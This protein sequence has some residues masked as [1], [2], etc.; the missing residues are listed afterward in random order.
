MTKLVYGDL[1]DDANW[2]K[3]VKRWAKASKKTVKEI[4]LGNTKA[5]PSTT[6]V[7]PELGG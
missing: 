5:A 1:L 6:K 3:F 7:L 2:I 4:A